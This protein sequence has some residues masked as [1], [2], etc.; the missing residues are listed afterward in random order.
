MICFKIIIKMNKVL[1]HIILVLFTLNSFSQ[2]SCLPEENELFEPISGGINFREEPNIDSKILYVTT[3][4]E[5]QYFYCVENGLNND[6]V[7][8]KIEFSR[9]YL[10]ENG[11]SEK[12]IGL[13]EHFRD[14]LKNDISLKS[15]VNASKIE[16]NLSDYYKTILIKNDSLTFKYWSTK[17]ESEETLD[18]STYDNFKKYF[19]INPTVQGSKIIEIY[20]NIGFVHKSKLEKSEDFMIFLFNDSNSKNYLNNLNYHLN[21]KKQNM[22]SFS[23]KKLFNSFS[24]YIISLIKEEKY[25]EAIKE[26]NK[27]SD[28]FESEDYIYV[29]D[30]LKMW[31]SFEDKNYVSAINLGKSLIK[32]YKTNLLPLSNFE[33]NDDAVFKIINGFTDIS[34]VYNILINSLKEKA[35]FQ[36]AYQYSLDCVKDAKLH[37]NNYMLDYGSILYHLDK[38]N[39]SCNVFSKEYLNGNENAKEYIEYYCK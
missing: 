33:D 39:E 31:I 12:F 11:I 13:Y 23:E 15:F 19:N 8:L 28:N 10:E 4:K 38:K 17:N 25:F 5:S 21:L 3:N 16:E 36:L 24:C 22:C 20:N 35:Y 26:T 2:I 9:D 14:S 34:T 29:I 1:L 30:F 6:F 32:S 7:K 37:Y 18:I 27:Y